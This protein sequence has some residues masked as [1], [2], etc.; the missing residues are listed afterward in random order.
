MSSFHKSYLG[1]YG[2]NLTTDID[3]F[4]HTTI[5]K[6]MA[7]SVDFGSEKLTRTQRRDWARGQAAESRKQ[8][9][10]NKAALA[11]WS[12]GG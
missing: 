1:R 11:E 6:W 9:T 3:G 4:V 12:A 8:L 7:A 2:E 10:K 5:A